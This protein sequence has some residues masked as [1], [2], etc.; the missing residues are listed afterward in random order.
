MNITL[1]GR[2]GGK[3]TAMVEAVKRHPGAVLVVM[4]E[5]EAIRIRRDYAMEPGT[6]VAFDRLPVEGKWRAPLYVD[7]ADIILRSLLGG[8][9]VVSCSM[10][11]GGK[12]WGQE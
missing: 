10:T 12:P 6:V 2:A 7:N 8:G 4:C 5:D 11:G 9:R 3:T 1:T